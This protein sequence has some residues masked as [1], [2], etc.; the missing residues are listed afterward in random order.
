MTPPLTDSEL[1]EQIRASLD[2]HERSVDQGLVSRAS[3]PVLARRRRFAVLRVGALTVA[4]LLL[5]GLV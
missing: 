2:A 4:I 3:G 5:V 1:L